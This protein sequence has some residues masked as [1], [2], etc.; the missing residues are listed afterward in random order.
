MPFVLDPSNPAHAEAIR[1]AD[2]RG[3]GLAYA[4][5]IVRNREAEHQATG[6]GC[7]AERPPAPKREYYRAEPRPPKESLEP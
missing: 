2:S 7:A 3:K 5:G 6:L 1:I 4:E